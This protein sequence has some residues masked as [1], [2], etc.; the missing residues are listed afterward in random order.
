MWGLVPYAP[1]VHILE[2]QDPAKSYFDSPPTQNPE[3]STLNLKHA[4]QNTTGNR[5]PRMLNANRHL[6]PLQGRR[7]EA[8]AESS[9]GGSDSD[10]MPDDHA[11]PPPGCPNRC[12]QNMARNWQS[13]PVSGPGF[14]V[15][16]L[17]LSLFP[18]LP[19]PLSLSLSLSL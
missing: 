12:R 9:G 13:R 3:Q 2:M 4:T 10:F 6:Q 5:R 14:Q 18:P 17:S 19:P 7:V 16:S 15:L 8:K 1:N 11:S